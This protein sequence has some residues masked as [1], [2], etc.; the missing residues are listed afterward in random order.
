VERIETVTAHALLQVRAVSKTFPGQVAL[1]GVDLEVHAGEVHAIVGQ[2]GSG[3]STLIK[4]LAGYHQPDPGGAITL[5]SGDQDHQGAMIGFV[6]QDLALVDTLNALDNFAL[7]RGFAIRR[8]RI[9]QRAERRRAQ[10]LMRRLGR[11]IDLDCPA[12]DLEPVERTL[13]A[14]ARALDGLSSASSSVL[15]LDEPTAALP[16]AD[17]SR[18]FDAIRQVTLDGGGVIYVSHRLDEVFEIADRVTVLRDGRRIAT[19]P[20]AGL[21]HDSLISLMLGHT[22]ERQHVRRTRPSSARR[23]M[24]EVRSVSGGRIEDFSVTVGAG[25]I[26]GVAGLVGSG[27][28]H[29]APAL[30]GGLHGVRG[31]VIVDGEEVRPLAPRAAIQAGIV[32][33]PAERAR[34][35]VFL[36]HSTGENITLPCLRPLV[37]WGRISLRRQRRDVGDWVGRV[38]LVPPDPDRLIGTLSGGNQQ[39]AILARWLRAD[40][41]VL[42]LD[43]PTQGV[44]IGA[45]DSI[46]ELL[47]AAADSGV[48]LLVCTVETE[49]FSELCERVL[50]MRDGR[51]TAELSGTEISSDRVVKETMNPMSTIGAS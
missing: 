51:V 30:V 31:Q 47:R 42:V 43:E 35:G 48:A 1:S 12:R 28:E 11:E 38:G 20:V 41:R 40:P 45:K 2:N 29:V 9:D 37:R 44:D 7:G 39:K 32:L 6:H 26:V 3:K 27:R 13:L 8:G 36:E 34:L 10:E 25:E 16:A 17:V 19:V 5:A 14:M 33:V 49:D 18:L 50:V 46:H 15:V 4:I 21:D 23:P 22:L 24:L